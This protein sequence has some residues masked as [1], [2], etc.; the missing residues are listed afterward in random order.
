MWQ[1]QNLESCSLDIIYLNMNI[2]LVLQTKTFIKNLV[3]RSKYIR[4]SELQPESALNTS[5]S[6]ELQDFAFLFHISSHPIQNLEPFRLSILNL[7]ALDKWN[8]NARAFS[9]PELEVFLTGGCCGD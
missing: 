7:L 9:S 4:C 1:F 2:N 6:G 5:R 8:K 3:L